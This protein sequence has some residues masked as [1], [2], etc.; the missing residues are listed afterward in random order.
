M[1]SNQSTARAD[2]NKKVQTHDTN[3]NVVATDRNVVTPNPRERED[4]LLDNRVK[5]ESL[6]SPG[7]LLAL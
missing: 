2:Q 1:G 5:C 4:P 3:T 6:F 7:C